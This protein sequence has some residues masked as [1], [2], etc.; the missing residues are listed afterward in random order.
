MSNELIEYNADKVKLIKQQIAKD[1]TDDELE[2]FIYHCKRTGLDP[3]TRQIY[4]IHR[5][6]KNPNGSYSK[7]MTIQVSIDGFRAVAERSGDYAGQDEPVYIEEDG[8]LKA[9]KVTVYKFRGDLRYPAATGV[10]YMD[11]YYP[12]EKQDQFWRKMPHIMLAKVAEAIA[13]RKAF[14]QDLSGVY[15]AAELARMDEGE[16]KLLPT[17]GDSLISPEQ[18]HELIAFA[19]SH[20]IPNK[21]MTNYIITYGKERSDQLTQSEFNHLMNYLRGNYESGISDESGDLEP[22]SDVNENV[23]QELFI[24]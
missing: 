16:K 23:D 4:C 14:P 8:K 9:C 24:S 15:E 3:L 19:K 22:R 5:N 17:N 1:A 21:D 20:N 12:P 11:E 2:Y 7:K 18:R 6:Q 13:L 10:A